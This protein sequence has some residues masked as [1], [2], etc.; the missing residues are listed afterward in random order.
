MTENIARVEGTITTELFITKKIDMPD[1]ISKAIK[2]KKKVNAFY[3][4]EKWFD[5]GTKENI[6]KVNKSY[7]IVFFI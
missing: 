4:F 1:I 3:V 7:N 2:L 5:Y 6:V